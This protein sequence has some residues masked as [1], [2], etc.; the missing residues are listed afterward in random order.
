M[1][2]GDV[3]P[4]GA[5]AASTDSVRQWALS[6]L[7][8]AAHPFEGIDSRR[9]R[10]VLVGLE[11]VDPEPWAGAWLAIA[12]DFAREA[13]RL[14]AERR[15]DEARA[16]WWQGHRFARLAR[17]PTPSHP[18]KVAAYDLSREFFAEA[19][20]PRGPVVEWAEAPVEGATRERYDTVT[21]FVARPRPRTPDRPPVVIVF[22]G[23]DMFKEETYLRTAEL[24]ARGIATLHVDI[25]GTGESPL[26]AGTGAERMW[27][28]VFDWIEDSDLDAERVGVLGMSF[29][30]YWATKLAHTHRARVRAA[31][32]WGGGI[33]RTFQREWQDRSRIA[34]T[35][36]PD[37][38][39]ARASIFGKRSFDDYVRLLPGLSLVQQGILDAPSSPQLLVGGRDDRQSD[40]ADIHLALEHG[41]PKTARVYAGGHM[42]AHDAPPMIFDWLESQLG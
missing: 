32:N 16:A 10:A 5:V 34:A 7:D 23:I 40:P 25:P 36:V 2:E 8:A 26:H 29:G 39:A 3:L 41:S 37:L 12:Q 31:V 33:H 35:F 27:T 6:R 42:S 1:R 30:G 9:A 17:F 11:S 38:D 24:R 14:G 4:S 19:V 28:P 18:A 21:F 20:S 15:S 22:S 13:R